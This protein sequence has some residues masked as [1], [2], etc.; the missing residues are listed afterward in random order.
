MSV[1]NIDVASLFNIRGKSVVIVGATGAFGKVVCTALGA[2]GVRLTI[3][4]GDAAELSRLEGGL[5]ARGISA[6]VVARRPDSEAKASAI[7]EQAVASCGGVDILVAAASMSDV[8][9]IVNMNPDR[10]GHVMRA[11][12]DGAWLIACAAEVN[13]IHEASPQ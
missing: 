8:S 4:A 2:T 12:V 5:K 3:A 11:N 9:P 7:V 6:H 13:L 10:L 1:P